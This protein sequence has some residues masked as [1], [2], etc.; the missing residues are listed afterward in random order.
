MATL[1]LNITDATC[2]YGLVQTEL[3]CVRTLASYDTSAYL[4]FQIG[5]C[6]VGSVT[7]IM[8][9][10]MYYRADKYDGSP[11]QLYSFLL[12]CYAALTMI[13]RG[14]DPASYGHIVPRPIGAFLSDSCTAA[15]YSVYVLALGYWATII[16][17]GAA[18][19]HKPTHLKCLEYSTIAFVWA[20]YIAYDMSLFAFKGFI[21]PTLNYVQLGV[22]ASVL[23]II[24]LTFLIYGFRVM[25]R[26][27]EY[28]RQ[29]KVT[30]DPDYMM[31]NHSFELSLSDS[32]D[33]IPEKQERRFAPRRPQEGHTTKIKKILLVAEVASIVVI[34]GQMYMVTQVSSSPIELACA[35]GRLC[36]TVKSKW[37]LLHIF[38]VVCVWVILYVFRGVQKKNVIPHPRGST[39]Y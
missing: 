25:T 26:L 31:S 7:L 36:N 6:V 22:S 20:F 4:H 24:A 14:A 16:Q 9:A 32:E 19:I 23:A 33:N 35:N 27:Q 21:P 8:S 13:V 5:Y 18:V 17:Q 12:C 34:A 30:L 28:E 38:Q 29:L 2:D 3:G 15:L 37:S 1:G 11:L 10:T 39:G